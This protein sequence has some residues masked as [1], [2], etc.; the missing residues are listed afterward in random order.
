MAKN[1]IIGLIGVMI[2]MAKTALEQRVLDHLR[3]HREEL[4]THISKLVQIDTQNFKTHG[5]ENAGQAYLESLFKASGL[6]VDRY[7]MASVNGITEHP[8]FQSGRDAEHRDNLVAICRGK[9]DKHAVMLAAHIDTVPFGD[10]AAWTEHPLSGSIRDGKIYGRGAGDDKYAIILSWYVLEAFRALGI[11]PNANILIGS[12]ADEEY[13]GCNGPLALCLKYPC[14]TYVNIDGTTLEKEAC[15]G[16]CYAVEVTS[17][18]VS[19]GVAS[20]FDVFDGV[21]MI[22]QLLKALNDRAGTTVRLSSF[23]GGTTGDKTALVKFAIYTD[24][25]KDETAAELA[26]M[27]DM[28]MPRMQAAGLSCTAFERCTRFFAYGKTPADSREA[29]LLAESIRE[30]RGTYEDIP[31]HDLTDLSDFM[32]NGTL[33]SMNFGMPYG[34]AEGGGAHQANEHIACEELMRC[35]ETLAL[36]LLRGYVDENQ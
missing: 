2:G 9:T 6:D 18:N 12:Y 29:A 25:T 16:A 17:H 14:E 31:P 15:G 3:E 30:V 10:L 26:R 23:Q 11:R 1:A 32:V 22:M 27:H 33:N 35:A 20:I 24:M 4:F 7:A 21:Q 8:E 19:A 36:F 13:G 28:V 5:N 34:S